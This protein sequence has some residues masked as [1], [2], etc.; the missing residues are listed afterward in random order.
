[1]AFDSEYRKIP[2]G[3]GELLQ[4]GSE[5]AL[6][7]VGR[8]VGVAKKAAEILKKE[9][10]SVAVANMRFVKP[11][12]EELVARLAGRVKGIV[13]LE[14]NAVMGGFG[15]A[16]MEC[17]QARGL[18]LVPIRTIGL[19]D[20]Y[21]E[22]GKPQIIREKLGLEPARVVETVRELLNRRSPEALGV[23]S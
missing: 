19:P 14:E 12:D 15:S 13:T 6:L 5:V 7:A 10:V 22:H 23:V 1:M 4:D 16:V 8:M 3:K 11:L 20:E 9:G 2:I 18:G 21:I 17:L